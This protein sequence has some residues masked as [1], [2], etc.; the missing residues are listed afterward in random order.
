[1]TCPTAMSSRQSMRPV[2]Y[3]SKALAMAREQQQSREAARAKNRVGFQSLTDQYTRAVLDFAGEEPEDD[4]GEDQLA[5]WERARCSK[6]SKRRSQ[7]NET[8]PS[9]LRGLI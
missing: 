8:A 5:M 7:S 9:R 4:G 3:T 6:S 2:A 1:M